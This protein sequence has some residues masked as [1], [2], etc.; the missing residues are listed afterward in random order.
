[1]KSLIKLKA[2]CYFHIEVTEFSHLQLFSIEH[3][4]KTRCTKVDTWQAVLKAQV[5]IPSRDGN[6]RKKDLQSMLFR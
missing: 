6:C 3:R 5:P 2:W 1:M 4:D